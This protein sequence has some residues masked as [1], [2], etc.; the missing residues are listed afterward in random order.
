[1]KIISIIVAIF[2][3]LIYYLVGG[4]LFPD[5][6]NYITISENG[7]WLFDPNEYFFEWASRWW[8]RELPNYVP[9]VIAVDLLAFAVQLIYVIWLIDTVNKAEIVGKYWITVLSGP[10]L[11]TTTLRGTV[12]YLAAYLLVDSK[13]R[14]ILK[15]SLILLMGLSFH[16]SFL[17]V[18]LAYIISYPLSGFLGRRF[19]IS[20]YI[21]S[22]FMIVFGGYLLGG[23]AS[24]ILILGIGI[25]DVYFSEVSGPSIIK[26]VYALFVAGLVFPIVWSKNNENQQSTLMIVLL[27]AASSILFGLS[28]T[29]AIR[30]LLFVSGMAVLV[31][32]SRGLYPS[33]LNK[34][35]V[36]ILIGLPIIF[37]MFWDLFRNATNAT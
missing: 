12:A 35:S 36:M 31:G 3:C 15:S 24:L 32:F 11:L 16:D 9:N 34:P 13:N 18:A 17:I 33:Y 26:I 21:F 8:L 37:L 5:Y 7:G 6:K 2:I 10:L 4:E 1:M 22:V 19:L 25:R 27:F 28:S 23:L 29:P 20:V 14:S 30:M